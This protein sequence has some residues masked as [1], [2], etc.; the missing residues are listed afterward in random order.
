[1]R[2]SQSLTVRAKIRV[3]QFALLVVGCILPG[4]AEAQVTEPIPPPTTPGTV[5]SNLNSAV[6][7]VRAKASPDECWTGLGQNTARDFI[8]QQTPQ[9]PCNSNQIPK[10]DQG[11]IW[12]QVLVGNQIF[13]GTFANAE[14]IGTSNANVTPIVVPNGWACEYA[15]SAFAFGNGGLLP[16]TIAD[17]RPPRMYLYDVPSQSIRDITPK[18]GGSPPASVCGPTGPI[19]YARTDYGIRQWGFVRLPPTLSQQQ[20]RLT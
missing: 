10:V 16:A 18:L 12:G 20:T 1:M 19:L 7:Y 6:G 3:K 8:H 4:F 5:I 2:S 14:C 11:Y 13:F 17:F 15:Q 9:T